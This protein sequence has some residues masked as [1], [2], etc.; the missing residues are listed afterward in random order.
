MLTHILLLLPLIASFLIMVFIWNKGLIALAV[1]IFSMGM[2]VYMFT[3]TWEWVMFPL[4]IIILLISL[5]SFIRKA[6]EGDLM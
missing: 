3:H 1:T 4:A 2:I 5:Y 6:V